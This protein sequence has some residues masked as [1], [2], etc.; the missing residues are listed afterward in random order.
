MTQ[1]NTKII[2]QYLRNEL[3]N[4]DKAQFE[5][6]MN[7]QPELQQE[8]KLHRDIYEAS[9]R[10]ALR[11]DVKNAAR[12]YHIRQI[13]KWG[14]IGLNSIAA[15]IAVSLFIA[16][17]SPQ[18]SLSSHEQAVPVPATLIDSLNTYIEIDNLAVQYFTIPEKGDAFF[19][20][21][22]VL[23]SI[24][25]NAFLLNGKPHKGETIFQF[26][27]AM[28]AADIVKAGLNTMHGNKQLETQG[29]FSFKAFTTDGKVLAVNQEVGV[30]LQVPVDQYKEGMMIFDGIETNNGIDWQNPKPLEKIPVCV[31]MS[32]LNF[33]PAGY[34]DRLDELKWNPSRASRDSLYLSLE[35]YCDPSVTNLSPQTNPAQAS[36]IAQSGSNSFNRGSNTSPSFPGGF[37]AM[38]EFIKANL[39][40][41]QKAIKDGISG[42]VFLRLI[43]LSDGT[44]FDEQI[45]VNAS[46]R[47]LDKEAIRIVR[48]MPKW[49]PARD[50]RGKPINSTVTIPIRFSLEE[51]SMRFP[52]SPLFNMGLA[53]TAMPQDLGYVM[54]NSSE[55]D[56]ADQNDSRCFDRI[57]PS[58][59]LG[60]WSDR[61]NKTNLATR[62]FERRMAAIH[63]ACNHSVLEMYVRGIN[64]PMAE[65]DRKVASMGYAEFNAFAAEQVG[66]VDVFNSHYE[67][68]QKLYDK[69]TNKL[70]TYAKARSNWQQSLDQSWDS[71]LSEIRAKARER[72]DIYTKIS[73]SQESTKIANNA[74]KDMNR[75]DWRQGPSRV[76]NFGNQRPYNNAMALRQVRQSVGFTRRVIGPCNIDQLMPIIMMQVMTRENVEIEN[77]GNIA[78]I[79]FND[80]SFEV[81]SGDKYIDV[82]A[83]MFPDD[84][85]TYR[86]IDMEEGK[87]EYRL[88]SKLNYQFAFIGITEKG[89]SYAEI[90]DVNG[91]KQGDIELHEIQ[92]NQLNTRLTRLNRNR[93]W[94]SRSFTEELKW[95]TAERKQYNVQ[96]QRRAEAAFRADIAKIIFP[97]MVQDG[98]DS[99]VQDEGEERA[100][101]RITESRNTPEDKM[102]TI[103]PDDPTKQQF[104]QLQDFRNSDD[105]GYRFNVYDNNGKVVYSTSDPTFLWKG[106]NNRGEK[107]TSGVYSFTC[108]YKVPES[109]EINTIEGSIRIVRSDDLPI[110]GI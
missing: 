25:Q 19:S 86:K 80:F 8:V 31:D 44:I 37:R 11:A 103:Y 74:L 63:K 91:G 70:V 42:T 56:S 75:A 71:Y 84:I 33:Y 87:F 99:N 2:D 27:E 94:R 60:F 22:G 79:E 40:Y 102:I 45:V 12:Q 32:E 109:P 39:Q 26:Q 59:V 77:A 66:K 13:I 100:N 98:A 95:I 72:H 96:K 35:D 30:Y 89:Y 78:K 17:S 9:I 73:E 6:C 93:D 16:F 57:L 67:R 10:S 4:S 81:E 54:S 21:Q 34:E 64:Q 41:P 88:N 106:T 1:N 53:I 101:T 49:T 90:C 50:S 61:F 110:G 83:Y 48:Q 23:I 85:K 68:L 18:A 65:I 36:P 76:A 97:C 105:R 52:A 3:S 7:E 69:K 92:E 46:D 24:P 51:V 62:E 108:T 82:Y 20:E 15:I 58:T 43:I 14:A 107:C 47:I 38:H 28:E 104:F 5:L 29:M 55:S